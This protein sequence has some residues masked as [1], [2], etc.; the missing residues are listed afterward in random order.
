MSANL[1]S[2]EFGCGVIMLLIVIVREPTPKLLLIAGVL[3]NLKKLI[4][5]LL[6]LIL[7]AIVDDDG[8]QDGSV[9]I[10]IIFKVESYDKNGA[11]DGDG[12]G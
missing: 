6:K 9:F 3:V 5:N 11:N 12:E 2:V 1:Y 7:Q 8:E 4:N 10:L